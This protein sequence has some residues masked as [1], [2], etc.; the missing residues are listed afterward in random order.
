MSK[1]MTW[2]LPHALLPMINH[3]EYTQNLS[4][5]ASTIYPLLSGVMDWYGCYL[6]FNASTGLWSDFNAFNED[7]EHEEQPALNPT[8]ALSLI[9]RVASA[10]VEMAVALGLT[11]PDS[12]TSIA[13]HLTPPSTLNQSVVGPGGVWYPLNNTRCSDVTASW[14]FYNVPT[15]DAC[16]AACDG[17]GGCSLISYCPPPSVNNASG[18]TGEHGQPAPNTCWGMPIDQLIHCT[19]TSVSPGN[20]G[21][22]SGYRAGGS[23]VN[24]TSWNTFQGGG[25]GSMDSFAFYPNWPSESIHPSS[26]Y[27]PPSTQ[28]IARVTA[29]LVGGDFVGGRGVDV[30]TAAVRAGRSQGNHTPSSAYDGF[31][32]LQVLQGMDAYLGR[33]FGRNQLAYAPGGGIENT[34]M[35]RAVT[36]MLLQS[37][38][39]TPPGAPCME[40]GGCGYTQALFPFWPRNES[41]SFWGLGGKGGVIVDAVFDGGMGAVASPFNATAKFTRGGA[42]S[43]TL[44]FLD[45]WGVGPAGR[46]AVDCADSSA[47]TVSWNGDGTVLSFLAPLGVACKVGIV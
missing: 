28:T 17:T 30:L 46:V 22:T 1:F 11:P 20:T 47:P 41:A 9:Q 7:M 16:E 39:N 4:F 12:Y 8:I 37:Y 40:A 36:E 34:G 44:Y 31:T 2:N 10:T 32:P 19:N 18:C 23:E 13:T 14:T 45:P 25:M 27:T 5:A 3:F 38:P 26:P 6:A 33:W 24:I 15:L 21:W 29:A 35:I 42:P 43:T